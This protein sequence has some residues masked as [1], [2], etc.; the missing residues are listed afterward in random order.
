MTLYTLIILPNETGT[1][2]LDLRV[3]DTSPFKKKDHN[4]EYSFMT[5]QYIENSNNSFSALSNLHVKISLLDT[6]RH[7]VL[8]HLRKSII[9]ST[10]LLQVTS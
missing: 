8:H 2:H 1:Y 5:M 10:V 7:N 6:P 9:F 4:F 3:C